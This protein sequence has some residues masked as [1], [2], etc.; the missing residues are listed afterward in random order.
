M[1]H[2]SQPMDPRARLFPI[3]MV[4]CFTLQL[5]RPKPILRS[6]TG[7]Q[8]E[9][10]LLSHPLRHGCPLEATKS[11]PVYCLYVLQLCLHGRFPSPS[12]TA[13]AKSKSCLAFLDARLMEGAGCRE[14]WLASSEKP[15][16][17]NI[18]VFPYV[19]MAESSSNDAVSF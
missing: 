7:F 15:T 16:I 18:A 3:A 2:A 11:T 13:I 10:L 12:E 5:L 4:A 1:K 6:N 14:Q 9:M 8:W 17:T 19:A